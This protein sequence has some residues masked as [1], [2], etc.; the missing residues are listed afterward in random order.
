MNFKPDKKPGILQWAESDRPREKLRDLGRKALSDAELLGILIA[1]GNRNETAVDLGKRLLA[2]AGNDLNQLA[3]MKL[4]EM[5][6]VPGIGPAKALTIMAALELGRRRPESEVPFRE[7]QLRS[8]YEMFQY[9]R[10][11][12][13][14]EEVEQFWI[15]L[16]N[17][18]LVPI[19]KIKIA[20]GGIANVF[21]DQ[22][23]IFHEALQVLSSQIVL[24]HN[25]PSGK[26]EPS[27]EDKRMT[28]SIVQ[29][30]EFL[31]IRVLDHLIVSNE[32]YFSFLDQGLL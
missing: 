3:K 19:R 15:I 18:S 24:V 9:I 13:L 14:D 16:L 6:Q 30:G 8:S 32:G 12:L 25:H 21:V 31:Q 4:N 5:C 7:T 23:R 1:T 29:S 11:T 10:P 22:R 17:H 28:A 27:P 26:L 20:E 2:K